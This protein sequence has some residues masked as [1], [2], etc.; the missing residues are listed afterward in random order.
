[1]IS[2]IMHRYLF[3]LSCLL[4]VVSCVPEKP[5]PV[6]KVGLLAPFEGERRQLGYHLLHHAIF[7]ATPEHVQGRRVEWVI[8]DTHGDPESA[9]QRARELLVDP[10]VLA[11]VGPLLPE[12]VVA[13]APLIAESEMAWWP[14]A[15]VG[16]ETLQSWENAID[17]ELAPNQLWGARAW[18]A[19]RRGEIT[20]YLDPQLPPDLGEFAAV[21]GEYP[22]PQD[23]LAWQA[24][25]H[26]FKALANATS[27]ERA[28]VRAVAE[29]LKLPPLILYETQANLFPGTEIAE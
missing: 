10:A 27:L 11:I 22:W 18:P 21:G 19:V 4:L 3:I 12:E 29:P 17:K 28:A 1:M 23:W 2:R 20:I 25:R 14:L 5:A 13:V 7:P 15:P 16:E 24:T 26:A 6:L 9:A 8:L